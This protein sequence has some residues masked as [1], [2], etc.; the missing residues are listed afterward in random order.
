MKRFGKSV[1]IFLAGTMTLLLLTNYSGISGAEATSKTSAVQ[2]TP[3]KKIIVDGKERVI[4]NKGAVVTSSGQVYIPLQL[5]SALLGKP[6]V[7]T[8][9]NS[10]LQV[11]LKNVS[12]PKKPTGPQEFAV[13]YDDFTKPLS[14]N[15]DLTTRTGN[16]TIEP[17]KGAHANVDYG[18]VALSTKKYLIPNDYTI[19]CSLL[20]DDSSYDESGVFIKGSNDLIGKTYWGSWPI[21]RFAVD[22]H[23]GRLDFGYQNRSEYIAVKREHGVPDKLKVIVKGSDVDV[24]FNNEYITSTQLGEEALKGKLVGLISYS[25]AYIKS[26]KIINNDK[27]SVNN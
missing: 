13:I 25:G 6:V 19:E 4:S 3:I 1:A 22:Q 5:V 27:L 16:W 7:W 20:E 15:W 10:T 8:Q 24:Y 26:F 2:T 14:N 23:A 17:G 12:P 11:G 18:F 9:K 21:M